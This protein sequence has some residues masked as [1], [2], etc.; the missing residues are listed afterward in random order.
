MTAMKTLALTWLQTAIE[1]ATVDFRDGQWDAIEQLVTRRG[2]VLCVQRTGW[3]KSM[4]YFV[5][6]KLMREDMA[7]MGPVRLKDVDE[8]Q[9]KMVATAKDA[10]AKGEIVITKSKSDEEMIG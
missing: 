5:A 2:R 6:A 1:N 4:V 3:G 8:S 10:A 7:A 9:A